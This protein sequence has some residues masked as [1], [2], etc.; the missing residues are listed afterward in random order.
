[1]GHCARLRTLFLGGCSQLG[2]WDGGGDAGRGDGTQGSGLFELLLG[3]CKTL[4]LLSLVGC[5]GLDAA[6]LHEAIGLCT[7][8]GIRSGRRFPIKRTKLRRLHTL[9]LGGCDTNNQLCDAIASSCG[10]CAL[11]TL[12]LWYTP[13]AGR[14]SNGNNGHNNEVA[15]AGVGDVGMQMLAGAAGP[16]GG[17]GLYGEIALQHLNLRECMNITGKVPSWL[18]RAHSYVENTP[19][20]ARLQRSIRT[21]DLSFCG[22]MDDGHFRALLSSTSSSSSSSSSVSSSSLSP[23]EISGGVGEGKAGDRGDDREAGGGGRVHLQTGTAAASTD[24]DDYTHSLATGSGVGS[25]TVHPTHDYSSAGGHRRGEEKGVEGGGEG[26]GLECLILGGDECMITERTLEHLPVHSLTTL[27]LSEL[28]SGR[29]RS[30]ASLVRLKRLSAL[31]IDQCGD[32]LL[33]DLMD[34]VS[35][36]PIVSLGLAGS[37]VEDTMLEEICDVRPKVCYWW[38]RLGWCLVVWI[39]MDM[40][41][42]VV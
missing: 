21:L 39:C 40:Y 24:A 27:N 25:E 8:E 2:T 41:G 11:T 38:N 14:G 5:R 31:H 18:G 3:S 13:D 7:H 23:D 33:R 36:C 42:Y 15:Q 29:I 30:F 20:A 19:M 37:S 10:G 6:Q 22:L 16:G 17:G 28:P 34:I 26:G 9:V 1:M 12:D 32:V 35:A 4:E